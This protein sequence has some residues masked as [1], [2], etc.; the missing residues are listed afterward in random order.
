MWAGAAGATV[1][2]GGKSG[3]LTGSVSFTIGK[4]TSFEI[5]AKGDLTGTKLTALQSFSVI[6]GAMSTQFDGTVTPSVGSVD[7]SA[8]FA[9]PAVYWGKQ[10]AVPKV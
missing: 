5:Y 1:T 2:Y 9:V 7:D 8:I 4:Q 3:Q 6:M 10:F